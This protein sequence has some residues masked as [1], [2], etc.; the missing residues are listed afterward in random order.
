MIIPLS[1]RQ[2]AVQELHH[3]NDVRCI[4]FNLVFL[5][6]SVSSCLMPEM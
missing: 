6:L 4:A 2:G 1:Y 3:E 5:F